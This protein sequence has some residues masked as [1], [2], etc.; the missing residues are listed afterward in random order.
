MRTTVIL[1]SL[2]G[3][4]HGE[5]ARRS[6]SVSEGTIAW[7]MHE[8]RRR[9]HEAMA[10]ERVARHARELSAEL[11]RVLDRDGCRA[12]FG[13][14]RAYGSRA[15]RRDRRVPLAARLGHRRDRWRRAR[16]RCDT[17]RTARPGSRWSRPNRAR[18]TCPPSACRTCSR[19]DDGHREHHEVV[20]GRRA[21]IEPGPAGLMLPDVA[22]ATSSVL[23]VASPLHS[24]TAHRIGPLFDRERIVTQALE[25][26][27]VPYLIST[28]VLSTEN[29]AVCHIATPPPLVPPSR[30]LIA[31]PVMTSIARRA[32]RQR[33]RTMSTVAP[34][35]LYAVPLAAPAAA[36]R[37][38]RRCSSRRCRRRQHRPA[39][40]PAA[41]T[42][43]R[44]NPNRVGHGLVASLHG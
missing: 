20:R 33:R 41:R 44:C 12:T 28:F 26:S 10:P 42:C 43:R 4:S 15:E 30:A 3:M 13:K 19:D 5:V 6:R 35:L 29:A 17:T 40:C 7:R 31:A 18:S 8:A 32:C 14:A 16:R 25:P 9:L 27:V 21:L 22:T 39:A 23:V 2:Q 36:R 38:R 37:H 1:V 11:S 24:D 34:E